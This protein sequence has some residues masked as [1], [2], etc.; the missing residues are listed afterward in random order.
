MTRTIHP[1]PVS[2]KLVGLVLIVIKISTTVI[3]APVK[4]EQHAV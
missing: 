2:V 3:L 1:T 4:T